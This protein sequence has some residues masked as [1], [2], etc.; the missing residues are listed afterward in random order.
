[1]EAATAALVSMDSTNGCICIL[2]ASCFDRLVHWQREHVCAHVWHEMHIV[3]FMRGE[4]PR[5]VYGRC[6]ALRALTC[7]SARAKQWTMLRRY[8]PRLDRKNELVHDNI[9]QAS[10]WE[11]SHAE[12][13]EGACSAS[14]DHAVLARILAATYTQTAW[15]PAKAVVKRQAQTCNRHTAI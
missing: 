12:L 10:Q 4:L 7:C 8:R 2:T 14:R 15:A 6:T 3:K 1:M 11:D 5:I 13:I 9:C